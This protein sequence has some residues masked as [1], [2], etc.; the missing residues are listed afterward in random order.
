MARRQ[1]EAMGI[2]FPSEIENSIGICALQQPPPKTTC[3]DN[4]HLSGVPYNVFYNIQGSNVYDKFC[5][6]LKDPQTNFEQTVDVYGN[7]KKTKLGKRTPPPNPSQFKDYSF[8]LSWVPNKKLH[9]CQLRCKDAF[10]DLANSQCGH[11]GGGSNTLASTASVDDGC[12]TYSWD[13]TPPPSNSPSPSPSKSST[14]S[15]SSTR[16]GS[17]NPTCGAPLCG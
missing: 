10:R 1:G 13:I 15:S 12:G 14:V 5:D 4:T 7:V 16:N 17:G 6:A 9:T 8:K 2:H 11:Q 3:P